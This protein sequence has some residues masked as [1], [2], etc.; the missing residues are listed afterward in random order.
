MRLLF[1]ASDAEWTASTRVFA[2]AARG[3]AGKGHE[4][5]IACPPGPVMA[6]LGGQ[7]AGVVDVIGIDADASGPKGTFDMRRAVKEKSPEVAFV[8]SVRDQLVMSAG[9]RFGAGG[10]V[11]RRIPAFRVADDEPGAIASRVAPA[12]I[13]VTTEEQARALPAGRW[14]IPPM[15][16]PLGVDPVA[17]DRL[18]A[19]SRDALRLSPTAMVLGCPF[20]VD[21][22]VRLAHVLRTLALLAPRHPDVR[23]VVFGASALHD[24]LR[25]HAAALG[26]APLL[27]FIRD[28]DYD[29][30]A[31]TKTCDCI[32]VAADH[33]AAALACLDAMALRLPVIAERSPL[34]EH[35]VADGITGVLLPEGDPPYLAAAVARVLARGELRATFGN[36][37][38]A[39]VEREFS[40]RA[41][42]E[43]FE[44]AAVAAQRALR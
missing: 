14:P 6:W 28:G 26:V 30:I 20:T 42:I 29:V 23:A 13:I 7:S 17:H 34:T 3:L 39:R 15:V 19:V 43:G 2:A 25:M 35:Y 18:D 21:G 24:E 32:W 11:L 8:H 36:A 5:S 40:E 44:R 4:V 38:R 9:M 12:G 22:R 37:G 41:M 16:V 27:N 1:L 33:D 10:A 31:I